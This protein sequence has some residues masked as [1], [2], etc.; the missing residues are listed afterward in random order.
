MIT[1]AKG[2]EKERILTVASVHCGDTF[3]ILAQDWEGVYLMCDNG[4]FV[5]ISTGETSDVYGNQHLPI[6][7]IDFTLVKK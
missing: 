6:R 4:T 1:I 5:E 2:I 3:V 7:N